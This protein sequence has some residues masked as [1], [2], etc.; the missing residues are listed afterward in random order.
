MEG[1]DLDQWSVLLWTSILTTSGSILNER[2]LVQVISLILWPCSSLLSSVLTSVSRRSSSLHSS[3]TVQHREVFPRV[4][5]LKT[6]QN[7]REKHMCMLYCLACRSEGQARIFN[8]CTAFDDNVHSE[9]LFQKESLYI[10]PTSHSE[11]VPPPECLCI[12]CSDLF[13]ETERTCRG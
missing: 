12:S 1:G 3:T 6:D 10:R 8:L 7:Q 9:G 13:G 5:L 4:G 2:R 11:I